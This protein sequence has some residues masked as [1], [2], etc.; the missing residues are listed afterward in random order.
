LIT[1]IVQLK[2]STRGCV[3]DP[4]Q[5]AKNYQNYLTQQ[6]TAKTQEQQATSSVYTLTN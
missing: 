5:M 1:S 4:A 3:T 2:I 6:K